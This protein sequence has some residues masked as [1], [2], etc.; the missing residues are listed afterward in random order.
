MLCTEDN[1]HAYVESLVDYK[2]NTSCAHAFDAFATGF[3]VTCDGPALS[4]FNCQVGEVAV[5]NCLR[6][7]WLF[8]TAVAKSLL[9]FSNCPCGCATARY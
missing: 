7:G 6:C 5:S 8:V 3:R 2:L 9:L 4:L 1:R